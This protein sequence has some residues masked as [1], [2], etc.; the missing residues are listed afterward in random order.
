LDSLNLGRLKV[1]AGADGVSLALGDEP[2]QRVALSDRDVGL[3][4]DF[5]RRHAPGERR[6]GFR[7]P[8]RSLNP[9]VRAEFEVALCLR[10]HRHP[11]VPVDLSLTGILVQSRSFLLPVRMRAGVALTFG[12]L[13]C[14]LTGEVVR[15]D[16]QL[17]ALHFVESLSNG[18][19]DPPEPLLAIY[20]RLEQEW[21][22]SRVH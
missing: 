16:G 3:L 2:T 18:N 5:L 17:M 21:L 11:V 14:T 20:R 8:F 19:L 10:G 13:E 7:V 15:R 4:Q 9:E 22:R 6:L 1:T 12:D